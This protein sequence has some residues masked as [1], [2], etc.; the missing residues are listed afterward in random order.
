MILIPPSY[1]FFFA[2]GISTSGP[3]RGRTVDSRGPRIP[4]GSAFLLLLTGY[5]GIR[6][7]FDSGIPSGT[8]TISTFTAC[9]PVACAYMIGSAGHA[10]LT[11]AINATTK[12][13]P[14]KAVCNAA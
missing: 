11:S 2:V 7:I 10:G 12:T 14:D 13:F 4:L 1:R 3:Y 9:V 8:H 6:I 5:S